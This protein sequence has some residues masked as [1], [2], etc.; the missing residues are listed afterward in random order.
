MN[1]FTRKLG[2]RLRQARDEQGLTPEQ[3]AE[4][5]DIPVEMYNRIERG[6]MLP[7]LKLLVDLCMGLGTT[8]SQVLG[9]PRSSRPV[10]ADA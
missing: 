7:G 4:L 9:F 5:A 6:A 10:E 3:V 1:D 8:P 2:N